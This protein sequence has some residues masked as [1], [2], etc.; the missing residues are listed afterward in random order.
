MSD[1]EL[2]AE[3]EKVLGWATIYLPNSGSR[4]RLG[5]LS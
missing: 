3:A 5:V 1:E 2:R 4:G